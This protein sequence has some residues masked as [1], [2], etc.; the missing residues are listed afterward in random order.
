MFSGDVNMCRSIVIG[1]MARK[2][3]NA[4]TWPIHH[5]WCHVSSVD[6]DQPSTSVLSG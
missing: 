2:A 5:H 3:M 6:T 4:T 1:R